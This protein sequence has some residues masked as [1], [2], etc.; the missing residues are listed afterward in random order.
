MSVTLK[1][2][3][4]QGKMLTINH[5]L[6]QKTCFG[7]MHVHYGCA[8]CPHK[9]DRIADPEVKLGIIVSQHVRTK[10]EASARATNALKLGAASPALSE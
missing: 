7:Y 9:S 1:Q 8:W 5:S 2:L 3:K 4:K 6:R 10:P